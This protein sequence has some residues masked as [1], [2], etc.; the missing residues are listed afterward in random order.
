M[1][2][3]LLYELPSDQHYRIIFMKRDLNEICRS[4]R[5]MLERNG[6]Q[7]TLQEQL[8]IDTYESHLE[9][10]ESWLARQQNMEVLYLVYGDIIENPGKSVRKINAFFSGMLDER[11][12]LKVIDRSL[13]RQR[14]ED[15]PD[16]HGACQV[17][18][19]E[20]DTDNVAIEAQL[21]ALGYM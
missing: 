21:K 9:E 16:G 20:R 4:Q 6:G 1:V 10:M 2:S 17:Q 12:M 5:I 13:Y 18:S 15:N 14:N 19:T 3:M 7:P 8:L 11:R